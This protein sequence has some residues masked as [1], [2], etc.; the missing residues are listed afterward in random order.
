VKD[1]L[2]FGIG[3]PVVVDVEESLQRAGLEVAAGIQNRPVPS[4]LLG[5]A[6]IVNADTIAAELLKM[7]FLVPLFSPSNRR[8]AVEEA[9][10]S[11]LK[12]PFTLIDPTAI[13]PRSMSLGAGSYI[14]AGC[15]LGGSAAIGRF[16]FLNRG[17]VIGHHVRLGEFVSI[18]PGAVIGGSVTIGAS[19][20]VGTGAT[21]LPK[22]VIGDNA[23]VGAGAVVTR[24]VTAGTTVVG[25]PARPIAS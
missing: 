12:T 14:N 16:G 9:E 19:V 1:I 4:H 7:P 5:N 10:K 13:V 24:N 18:G 3:S 20:L 21:V 15:V 22:V 25:N 11:G 2:L 23:I 8:T 17:A 6:P